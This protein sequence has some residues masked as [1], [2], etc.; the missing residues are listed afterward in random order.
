[1]VSPVGVLITLSN[2]TQT[3]I[4]AEDDRARGRKGTDGKNEPHSPNSSFLP[5][6]AKRLSSFSTMSC[7]GSLG[8]TQQWE[9]EHP[10]STSG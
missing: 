9:A 3:N 7:P 10:R 8:S 1:M 2:H 4:D 6:K 5:Q